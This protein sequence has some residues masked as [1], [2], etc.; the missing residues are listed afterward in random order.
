VNASHWAGHA[1]AVVLL[2]I[3]SVSIARLEREMRKRD[4]QL[5]EAYREAGEYAASLKRLATDPRRLMREIAEETRPSHV[6]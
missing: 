3:R 1:V 2:A 4:E 5:R 6:D